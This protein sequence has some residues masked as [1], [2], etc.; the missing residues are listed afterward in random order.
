[1]PVGTVID[2]RLNQVEEDFGFLVD[3]FGH[4]VMYIKDENSRY[5]T[6]GTTVEFTS[7]ENFEIKNSHSKIIKIQLAV[8]DRVTE[9]FESKH[10]LISK[11]NN[12]VKNASEEEWPGKKKQNL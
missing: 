2:P 11:L 12:T 10:K 3:Q 9:D 4:M 7:D 8:I 5:Y 1:M 6:Q